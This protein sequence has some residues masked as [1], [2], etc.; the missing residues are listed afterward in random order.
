MH[1]MATL[2]RRGEGK[3]VNLAQMQNQDI[4]P[5]VRLRNASGFSNL[6]ITKVMPGVTLACPPCL[7]VVN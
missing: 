4:A 3:N 1:K 5:A 7:K 6:N 2:G